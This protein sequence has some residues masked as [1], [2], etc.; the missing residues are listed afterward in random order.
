MWHSAS[1]GCASYGV[2]NLV[3]R[4]EGIPKECSIVSL[5]EGEPG[6]PKKQGT[7]DAWLSGTKG[8][9]NLWCR[10]LCQSTFIS[11]NYSYEDVIQFPAE[12]QTS[13]PSDMSVTSA[14]SGWLIPGKSPNGLSNA[15]SHAS[16]A[17]PG[18]R[19]SLFW[20]FSMRNI[21]SGSWLSTTP[22]WKLGSNGS[23]NYFKSH[24][25]CSSWAFPFACW[26]IATLCHTTCSKIP[27]KKFCSAA[28][29]YRSHYIPWFYTIAMLTSLLILEDSQYPLY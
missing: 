28:K 23:G 20:S 17:M 18:L 24:C 15:A 25:S 3:L 10:T 26:L 1:E 16:D 13:A 12:L 5:N 22:A 8:N 14:S 11:W 9:L 2:M 19:K 7:L 21:M 6:N 29:V 4:G 27:H